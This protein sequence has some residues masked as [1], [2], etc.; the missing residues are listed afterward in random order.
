MKVFS[1]RLK[2]ER[3]FK[4]LSQKEMAALLDIP[5]GA[6]KNYELLGTESGREPPLELIY[7]MAKILD[8]STDY[9]FGLED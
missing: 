7:K 2:S 1:E 6:Y 9:L 5:Y 3:K 4:G 8:I